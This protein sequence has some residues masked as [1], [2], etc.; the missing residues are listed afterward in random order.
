MRFFDVRRIPIRLL[1]AGTL[2]VLL[3]AGCGSSSS[4][5]GGTSSKAAPSSK[6][7]AAKSSTAAKPYTVAAKDVSPISDA[8]VSTKDPK[9]P[10]IS[11]GKKPFQVNKTTT[12]VLHKG[13]GATADKAAVVNYTV[14]VGSSGKTIA[15][16]YAQTPIGMVLNDDTQLPGLVKAIKGAK[17]GTTEVAAIPP[18]DGFGTA[19][20]SD[21]GV[22]GKDTLVA[23]I[24]VKSAVD[25]L[26]QAKGK[27]VAPKSGMPKVKWNGSSKP[28]TITA[29]NTAPPKKL[30]TQNLINGNGAT[31][32]K[33][34]AL[35]AQYTG[36][37][38]TKGKAGKV[39]DSTGNRKG[40]PA[41][42]TIGEGQVIPGWDK[43]LVGK[44][45]GDRVLMVVPPADGYGSSGNPQGGIKGTDTL[46]FVV[47]IVGVG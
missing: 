43:A 28:A 18:T 17:V 38:W 34:Q 25:P 26:P 24:S 35:F 16:T 33:G 3:L 23:Y 22:T 45:V 7:S 10:K 4:N 37:I 46:M 47:D 1:A 39:F 13:T 21:L 29:P 42:F 11:L 8:K 6:A 31:V 27:A 20:R 15:N 2:P 32:K 9:S 12:K 40:M 36:A 5:G 30:Q 41:A 44:K 14:V 19:G